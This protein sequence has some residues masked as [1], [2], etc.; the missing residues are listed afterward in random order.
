MIERKFIT[1]AASAFAA[2]KLIVKIYI[3][4][5]SFEIKMHENMHIK[6][7]V[8]LPCFCLSQKCNFLKCNLICTTYV[9]GNIV[10]VFF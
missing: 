1:T 5:A 9:F 7:P 3:Q 2:R 4:A 6:T 8:L 10:V